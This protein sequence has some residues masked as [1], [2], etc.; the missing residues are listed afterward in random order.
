MPPWSEGCR[1]LGVFSR[2]VT[3]EATSLTPGRVMIQST[4][5]SQPAFFARS[6]KQHESFA[7]RRG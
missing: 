7:L 1:P 6:L 2:P 5:W 4:L 3:D